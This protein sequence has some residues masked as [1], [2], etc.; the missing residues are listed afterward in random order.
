MI[1][2]VNRL[3]SAF[4]DDTRRNIRPNT[5][6]HPS[7]CSIVINGEL[8][9]ACHR[10]EYYKWYRYPESD[11]SD[12]EGMLAALSGEALHDMVANML[13][14]YGLESQLEI[15]SIEESFYDRDELI[16]GRTDLFLLDKKTNKLFGVE[17]KTVGEYK[18]GLTMDQPDL[19]H[20]MQSMIYL[21][22]YNKYMP[23]KYK[24]VDEWLILYIARSET[25]KTRKYAHGSPFKQMW[26]FGISLQIDGSVII[27]DMHGGKTHRSDV[28]LDK[29]YGRYR[30]LMVSIRTK[31]IPDREYEAQYDEQR[32]A[33]MYKRNVGLFKKQ[34]EVVKK[35]L[36]AGAVAGDLNLVIGDFGCRFC[37]FSTKCWGPDSD[38]HPGIEEYMYKI[39]DPNLSMLVDTD[40]S[41]LV[42]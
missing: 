30:D 27:E 23:S 24:Q 33:G 5:G 20:V 29:L 3:Y 2:I 11:Q 28:T 12:P 10:R 35:W 25:Y 26:Q 18:T 37:Q 9:G 40:V 34:R 16:S 21:N 6:M 13:R 41:D 31:T 15:V 22:T 14:R 4:N 42:L 1:D 8:H 38:T 39:P 7:A 36:D 19:E 32:I 17:I